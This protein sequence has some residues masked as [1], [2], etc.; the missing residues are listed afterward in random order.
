M[1]I[2]ARLSA[3]LRCPTGDLAIQE[4]SGEAGA[5]A[6]LLPSTAP[7]PMI[8]RFVEAADIHRPQTVSFWAGRPIAA[9]CAGGAT[10]ASGVTAK[11]QQ[12]RALHWEPCG[13]SGV[14]I[15]M[16]RLALATFDLP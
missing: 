14:P 16:G 10:V 4:R 7:G 8:G 2:D 12:L 15:S 1:A 3:G 9:A 6:W 5:V 13:A 11:N